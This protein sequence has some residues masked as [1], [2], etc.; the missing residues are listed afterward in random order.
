MNLLINVLF[1]GFIVVIVL[2]FFGILIT[3][4]KKAFL[5]YEEHPVVVKVKDKCYVAAHTTINFMQEGMVH[6]PQ[7]CHYPEEYRVY[8]EWRN[9]V[10]QINSKELYEKREVEEFVTVTAHT[11][12]NRNNIEKDAYLTI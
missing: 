4:V 12:Y 6:V 3:E 11:G 9:K 10:Y 2:A 7:L 5:R 1:W 8:V